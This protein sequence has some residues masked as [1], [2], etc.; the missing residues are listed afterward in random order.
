[1]KTLGFML[2]LLV[3]ITALS[4]A[5]MIPAN[6]PEL[7]WPKEAGGRGEAFK[8]VERK[9]GGGIRWWWSDGPPYIAA[10]ATDKPKL[11]RDVT[12]LRTELRRLYVM[13]AY[14][15]DRGTFL[16]DVAKAQ[17]AATRPKEQP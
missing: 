9:D 3:N 10:H 16:V 6:E 11:T 1:M 12:T 5:Q 7:C 17:L 4:H 15:R 14:A 2:F 13:H 8:W